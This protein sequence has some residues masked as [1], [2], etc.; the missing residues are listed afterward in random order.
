MSPKQLNSI[1]NS[2]L[3]FVQKGGNILFARLYALSKGV[4]LIECETMA[5]IVLFETKY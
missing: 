2:M 3:K 1:T 5:E 4:T